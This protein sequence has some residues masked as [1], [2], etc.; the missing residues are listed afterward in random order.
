MGLGTIFWVHN[1]KTTNK[2][3]LCY[4]AQSG[5][6]RNSSDPAG[7]GLICPFVPLSL[8]S[9][10]SLAGAETFFSDLKSKQLI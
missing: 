2:Q 3:L 6:N 7:I 5:R 10:Y 9:A 8:P 4:M 1:P